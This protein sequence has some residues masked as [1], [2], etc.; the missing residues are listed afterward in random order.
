MMFEPVIENVLGVNGPRFSAYA[1]FYGGCMVEFDDF[2]VEGSPVLIM[3]G[4]KDESMSI[5]ACEAFRDKLRSLGVTAELAV[6][7]GAGHGWNSPRPQ[8]F[9]EG[10]ISTRDCVMRW[11]ADGDVIETT[12]GQSMSNPIGAFRAISSCSTETGYTIGFN[13]EAN[14]Q[15]HADLMAFLQRTWSMPQQ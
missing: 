11:T 10:A 14:E 1:M 7:P 6:Y 15:S 2:R 5:P 9:N 13:K 4:E 8:R 12:S 3:M